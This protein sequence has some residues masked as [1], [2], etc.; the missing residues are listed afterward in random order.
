MMF[1][2]LLLTLDLVLVKEGDK[3]RLFY[4]VWSIFLMD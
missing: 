2:I 4:F 3:R 1:Q